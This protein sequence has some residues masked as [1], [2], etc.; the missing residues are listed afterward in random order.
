MTSPAPRFTCE[1]AIGASTAA[2]YDL[3][4]SARGLSRWWSARLED[5]LRVG[6]VIDLPVGDASLHIR[7]D[8]LEATS[9][10]IW[11]CVGGVAEWDRSSIRFDLDG[12]EM[13]T[14]RLEHHGWEFRRPGGVL[15]RAD[16]SWP[17]Q[18]L[19][20]RALVLVGADPRR[21][22]QPRRASVPPATALFRRLIR[23][24]RLL[25][26]AQPTGS[27]LGVTTHQTTSRGGPTLWHLISPGAIR[28]RRSRAAAPCS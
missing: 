2:A 20:L 23:R 5:D 4:T 14:L 1:V 13:T 3:L 10:V 8:R 19:R 6:A 12:S 27:P 18:L 21:R 24:A 7:V 9:L 16:F 26:A 28:V 15:E 25:R 22:A 11:S 17:R